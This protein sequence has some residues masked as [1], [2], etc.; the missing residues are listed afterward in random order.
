MVALVVSLPQLRM[1]GISPRLGL[2]IPIL[3]AGEDVDE[4]L[5]VV[6]VIAFSLM[7]DA[8]IGSLI[9][10]AA[11]DRSRLRSWSGCRRRYTPSGQRQ[12]AGRQQRQHR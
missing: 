11:R 5:N 9:T 12:A 2:D 4:E 3:V 8:L 10:L 1:E 6:M 7:P